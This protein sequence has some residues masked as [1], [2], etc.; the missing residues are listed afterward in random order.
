M[1]AIT[2]AG[3]SGEVWGLERPWRAE[4][5]NVRLMTRMP[6]RRFTARADLDVS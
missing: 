2:H 3:G 5:G 6:A 4:R 1:T